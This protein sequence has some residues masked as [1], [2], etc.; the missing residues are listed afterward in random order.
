MID[1]PYIYET[2]ITYPDVGIDRR[3]DHRGLLRILQEAAAIASDER[4][5]GAK[6]VPR[7]GVCWLLSGWLAELRTRPFWRTHLRTETWPRSLDGFFSERDFLVWQGEELIARGSSKWILVNAVT[8]KLT[9]VTDAVRSAYDVEER[10]VFGTPLRTNGKTP[11][12]TPPAFSTLA[13]RRDMD[14]NRHVNNIH[15]LDYALEAL[16]Q[17]VF[18]RLPGT[19]E[20]AFRRQILEGTPIRC[21]YTLTEDGR[22]QVEIQSGGEKVTRHAFVWFYERNE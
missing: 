1:T 11:P 12:G 20:V 15:Y 13:G 9:R 3:L 7:T 18:D 22:H 10:S 2:D 4:G 21:L 6:D 19:V 14:V 16:P 5:Y 17:E 8:G